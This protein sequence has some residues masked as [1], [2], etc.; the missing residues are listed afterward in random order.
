MIRQLWKSSIRKYCSKKAEDIVRVGTTPD[1]VMDEEIQPYWKAL[2]SRVKNRKSR[3]AGINGQSGR[4]GVRKTEE[5]FWLE[6][7]LY[8]SN[9]PSQ[10]SS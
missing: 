9:E 6:A 5:D 2:E 3:I 7:G 1:D 8:D 4:V 10:N